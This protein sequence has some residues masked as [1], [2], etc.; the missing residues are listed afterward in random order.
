MTEM[1]RRI[2]T[3]PL[4]VRSATNGSTLLVGYAAVFNREAVIAGLF[5]EQ[6]APGA[7]TAAIK[8]DDV[9]AMYNHD[10]AYVL[11]RNTAGTLALSEDRTGLRY[12]VIINTDDPLAMS[13]LAKVKRGDVSQS[14]FGFQLVR[15][16]WTK[17]E[18]RADLPLRTILE[19][20]LFDVSPVA[21]PAYEDTSATAQA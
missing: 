12:E 16:Q 4:E 8:E 21:F 14:S 6:I 15:E 5:R 10:P 7:F 9:R 17:P 18:D 2:V 20:R 13:V 3:A 11:G 19:A 1:Q